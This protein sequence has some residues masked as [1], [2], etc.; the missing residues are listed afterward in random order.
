MRIQNKAVTLKGDS[1]A[2]LQAPAQTRRADDL[3]LVAGPGHAERRRHGDRQSSNVKI[4]G[5]TVEG[6]FANTDCTG[7]DYGVLEVGGQL[8]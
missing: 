8:R 4:E 1:G 5:L 7:D 6:P 2:T 3:L